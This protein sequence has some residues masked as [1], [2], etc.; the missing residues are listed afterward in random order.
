MPESI[1]EANTEY[2][3]KLLIREHDPDKALQI[4]KLLAEQD[5]K[6]AFWRSKKGR[7][8]TKECISPQT[9]MLPWI[10]CQEHAL[11]D[12]INAFETCE[13]ASALGSPKCKECIFAYLFQKAI[14][15][16]DDPIRT[17]IIAGWMRTLRS[18]R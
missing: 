10:K 5:A 16:S 15:A 4:H 13:L 3:S 9:F 17:P 12:G 7:S 6:L 1:Y 11:A 14:E 8:D 2:W 18:K